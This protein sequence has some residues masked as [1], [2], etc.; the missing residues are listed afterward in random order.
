MSDYYTTHFTVNV[1]NILILIV[2]TSN[3]NT[4]LYKKKKKRSLCHISILVEKNKE[5]IFFLSTIRILI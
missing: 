4:P 3:K 2:C 5:F 1:N